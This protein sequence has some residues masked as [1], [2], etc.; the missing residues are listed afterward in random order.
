MERPLV[1]IFSE[2]NF[3]GT[4]LVENFLAKVCN[5]VV[6]SKNKRDW[7][8][9]TSHIPNKNN[10]SILE[11]KEFSKFDK[12]NYSIFING[13]L[14]KENAYDD[15]LN[16][17]ENVNSKSFKSLAIF[18]LDVFDVKE[19]Q[20]L[21]TNSH[22]GIVYSGDL[23]GP[24]M[25]LESNLLLTNILNDAMKERV[26]NVGIGET[27]YPL[28]VSDLA[29]TIVKWVF[30][31]G[32]YGKEVFVLGNQVSA[33]TLWNEL[34][35]KIPDLE[36]TYDQSIKLRH[37]PRKYEVNTLESNVSTLLK[38]TFNWIIS[39]NIKP[40][41]AS[42]S[43]V[44]NNI[45][46]KA[47][48]K[49]PTLNF[50]VSPKL[51]KMQLPIFITT[52]VLTFP[53]ICLLISSSLFYF[54][55]KKFLKGEVEGARNLLLLSKTPSMLGKEQ[56]RIFKYIPLAGALYK[57]SYYSLNLT[58][59]LADIGVNA[60]YLTESGK[61]FFDKVLGNEIYDPEKISGEIAINLDYLNKGVSLIHLETVS[62]ASNDSILAKK[63]LAKVDFEKAK[64]VLTHGKSIVENLPSILGKDKRKTY[65]VLFQNNMELRPTGGFI[66]SFG[67]LTFEGG[68]MSD[69]S[70]SDV[71][72][73][74]GQL[75]GHVEPPVPIRD[76]LNEANWFLR[77]S[78]WDPDFPTS[79]TRAE[80]FL[81]K[82]IDKEVDGVIA[83]D[84]NLVKD[85]LDYTGP[86]HLSDYK[87]DIT[88]ENLYLKTQEE[89]HEDFFPGTHKKASFLTSLSRN[90][91][92]EVTNLSQSGKVHV[93][94][95]IFDNLE[96]RHIQL[97]IHNEKVQS[98]ISQLVWSGEVFTPSCQGNCFTDFYGLVEAN[99]G[100]NKANY[101]IERSQS[102]KSEI[103]N[104]TVSNTLT[105]DLKNNANTS[106]GLAGKYKSYI[107]VLLPE[108]AQLGEIMDVTGGNSTPVNPEIYPTKGRREMGFLVEVLGEQSKKI[109]INWTN[110]VLLDFNNPG[111][112]R[113]YVRKQAGTSN[114][115]KFDME[116]SLPIWDISSAPK[117]TLTKDGNF[118][119]NTNL[120][121]DFYSRIS[122]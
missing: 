119:Y 58:Q 12:F 33:T 43:R 51:L 56:S 106:L 91:V 7:L 113:L 15:F 47:S 80:W 70:V 82:E 114:E 77:D 11:Q 4:Y 97:Y 99:V 73:A 93:L 41:K 21:P 121:R 76:Y 17:F 59:Q 89:V 103:S 115:D 62:E 110:K 34:K 38:E 2:P 22:L 83:L 86:I 84:L 16:I 95:E 19:S 61:G 31:F 108:N 13:F 116:L 54:S 25:D 32:P 105:L 52:L 46:K 5:V 92:S 55:Y 118:S 42:E 27:F 94:K 63:V 65:L 120:S 37:M 90:L 68:R 20:K 66:G 102:L 71:Y 35:K 79:A 75:K 60:M 64:R 98:S 45:L 18:P 36:I 69:L 29:K 122:W 104:N 109:V 26:I 57:E 53:L 39:K 3:L 48:V 23:L 1:A 112:Y 85:V 100:V 87:M 50:S 6:F 72:S 111:E 44:S 28:F 14:K 101:F 24:R 96:E 74:D 81:S 107:R 40:K 9:R 117:L 8:N 10:L 78:N 49:L 88:S 30:S 67:L